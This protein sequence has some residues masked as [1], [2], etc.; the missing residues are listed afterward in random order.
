MT[1]TNSSELRTLVTSPNWIGDAV[2]GQPLLSAL[3]QQDPQ[4]PIDVLAPTWVAP[5]WRAIAEVDTF[6]ET[7]FKHGALQR[8]SA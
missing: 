6:I 8:R 5:V 4:R 7:P 1:R 3:K 2:M